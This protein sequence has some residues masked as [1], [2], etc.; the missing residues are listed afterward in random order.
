MDDQTSNVT[1][2][3]W[4]I[5]DIL[6][7]Y[8]GKESD[9]SY[10]ELFDMVKGYDL[11]KPANKLPI[12]LYVDMCNWIETKLGKFNLIKI[13]RN[14]GES[15]YRVMLE[16]NLANEASS[17]LD[18]MNALVIT[19]QKGVRDEKKRGWIVLEHA[20]RKIIMRKTQVFN[21]SIQLGMLDY[22]VRKAKVMGV[23]VE[24]V[25]EIAKGNEFDDYQITWL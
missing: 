21:A 11:S 15:T 12:S 20:D 24:L 18:I 9:Y 6:K 19:A 16:K 4:T 10:K 13:G 3:A 7:N 14:I 22:L 5:S 8:Q 1:I 23:K 25:G 2:D 17:P